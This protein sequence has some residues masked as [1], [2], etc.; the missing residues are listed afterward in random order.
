MA[1]TIRASFW[2]MDDCLG[3]YLAEIAN[4]RP[5]S[6]SE[7]VLLARRIKRGDEEARNRLVEANLRFVVSVAKEYQN[8]GVPLADLISAGN[9][10]LITAAERF[11][12]NK[13]FKFISYAVW[14]IRQAILQTLAEQSRTVR[15][16]LNKIGLLYKI[17][18][19]SRHLQ[20]ERA[21]D[22]NPE[23]IAAELDVPVEEVKETLM[24]GR[25]V[26]SLDAAFREEEDHSLLDVLPDERQE[27]P[28]SQVM[29]GCLRGQIDTALSTLMGREAEILRLYF[30]LDGEEPMTLD[31]IGV[32]FGLTRERVRQIKEKAL[33]RLRHPSRCD[34]LRTYSKL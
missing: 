33:H 24:C 23:D 3:S 4:S 8:R 11:D 19:A 10:G 28:E 18:K 2:D 20:Q 12:E 14:W 13:G 1:E 17:S 34:Q 25:S 26:R 31:Q 6:S 27:S 22:P 7:E 32:R 30:G 21:D 15:L 29:R 16:P 5:L 9:M